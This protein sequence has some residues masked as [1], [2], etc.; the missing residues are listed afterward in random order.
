MTT[1]KTISVKDD[2]SAVPGGRYKDHGLYS[3]EEFRDQHLAPALKEFERVVV[4][5]SGT[6]GYPGSFLEEA[7]GGLIRVGGFKLDDLQ[8]RLEIRSGDDLYEVYRALAER[9]MREAASRKSNVA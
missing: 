2:F 6:K 7:F 3:G 5:L 1:T 4:I 8:R 9:Y